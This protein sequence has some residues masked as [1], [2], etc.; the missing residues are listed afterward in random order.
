MIQNKVF[1][2][3]EDHRYFDYDGNEYDSVSKVL[4]SVEK[5]FDAKKMSRLVAGKGKYA[6]LAADEIQELWKQNGKERTGHG[7]RIHDSLE[8]YS[9]TGQ[10]AEKNEELSPMIQSISSDYR[11]YSK[12][13]DECILYNDHYGVAGTADKVL[14]IGGSKYIDIEDYKTSKDKGIEYFS[15]YNKYKLEP[16][17]HLPDCNFIRYS[18][19]LAIYAVMCEGLMGVKIRSLWIRYIPADDPLNHKR[20]PVPYMRTDALAVL[21]HYVSKPIIINQQEEPIF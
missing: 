16:I 3:P 18:L 7:T 21:N 2:R 15:K 11:E 9:K 4:N 13:H 8:Q 14:E 1:L 20:I 19:Q 5:K 17:T 6:G 10:I 12:V